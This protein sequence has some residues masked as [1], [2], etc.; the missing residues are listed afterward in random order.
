MFIVM[1]RFIF[2]TKNY[3]NYSRSS[4]KAARRDDVPRG[5]RH[6]VQWMCLHR[7]LTDLGVGERGC[8][9]TPGVDVVNWLQSPDLLNMI[10]SSC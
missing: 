6:L 10:P 4:I 9:K 7:L 2:D 5:L 1:V 3:S 8:G